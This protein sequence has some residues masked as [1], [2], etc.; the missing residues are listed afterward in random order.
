ELGYWDIRG[1]GAPLRMLLAYAGVDFNDVQFDD[2]KQWFG[3]AGTHAGAGGRRSELRARNPLANLP[4]VVDGDLVVAQSNACL[5][6]LGDKYDLNGPDEAAQLRCLQLVQE[7]YDLRNGMIELAYPQKKK[8]R[9][10]AEFAANREVQLKS[11]L[12]A[13]FE[14]WLAHY[15]TPFFGGEAPCTAD[16]PIWEM[17]DQYEKLATSVGQS[18]FSK[19]GIPRCHAFH[20]GF[21]KLP[22]LQAYFDSPAYALPCNATQHGAF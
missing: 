14:A 20:T 8:S 10:A 4:Y 3:P 9:D 22:Q 19:E 12:F 17:L 5:H 21:R 7:V 18:L 16:F 6:Y 11:D 2:P 1:L 13:K 15:K